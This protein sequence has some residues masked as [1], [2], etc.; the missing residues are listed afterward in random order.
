MFDDLWARLV[1]SDQQQSSDK[2]LKKAIDS[3]NQMIHGVGSLCA[4]HVMVLLDLQHMSIVIERMSV[5]LLL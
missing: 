2:S 1:S 4:I 5:R 3:E